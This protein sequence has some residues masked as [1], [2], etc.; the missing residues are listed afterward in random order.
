MRQ[1]P[2]A[3]DVRGEQLAGLPTLE[4]TVDRAVAA[5]YGVRVRDA[6]DAIEAI[7]GHGDGQVYEG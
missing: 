2:G 1:V 5:R 6:L 3:A 7:G 4:V